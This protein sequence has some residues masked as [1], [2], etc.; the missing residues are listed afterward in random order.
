VTCCSGLG[1]ACWC[2]AGR[3][4]NG[5]AREGQSVGRAVAM[6]SSDATADSIPAAVHGRPS[7]EAR[8]QEALRRLKLLR[9]SSFHRDCPPRGPTPAG[10]LRRSFELRGICVPISC[11]LRWSRKE[12]RFVSPAHQNCSSHRDFREWSRLEPLP[13]VRL[14]RLLEEP[15]L[16]P[17]KKPLP[18]GL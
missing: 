3:H 5:A 4:G 9:P 7:G 15:V 2:L 14:A 13:N 1:G 17:L 10:R 18:K 6:M 16:V 12:P 8:L 11:G